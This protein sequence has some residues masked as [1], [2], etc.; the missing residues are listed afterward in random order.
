MKK[1]LLTMSLLSLI[2]LS[3][4]FKPSSNQLKL[5]GTY[6]PNAAAEAI[7]EQIKNNKMDASLFDSK[8]TADEFEGVL[9][10]T[11]TCSAYPDKKIPM[12]G[13]CPP[14]A[15]LLNP[16]DPPRI[17]ELTD[18]QRTE[19][20]KRLIRHPHEHVRATAIIYLLSDKTIPTQ[21]IADYLRLHEK[22]DFVHFNALRYML[23][24]ADNV[25]QSRYQSD[26]MKPYL[27]FLETIQNPFVRVYA[28][29]RDMTPEE[30]ANNAPNTTKGV[31]DIIREP[32]Y[33]TDKESE[34]LVLLLARCTLDDA[35]QLDTELCYAYQ[36][37]ESLPDDSERMLPEM[38]LP[39]FERLMANPSPLV[40][41]F[42]M[43]SYALTALTATH[44][45][46]VSL[47][48]VL[49]KLKKESSAKAILYTFTALELFKDNPDVKEAIESFKNHSNTLISR[50]VVKMYETQTESLSKEQ[51]EALLMALTACQPDGDLNIPAD[52]E[53]M[54]KFR[55]AGNSISPEIALPIY[56]AH[57]K[58]ENE[59]VR[60]VS[61]YAYLSAAMSLEV[62]ND[63]ETI[64]NQ[65]FEDPS[66]FVQKMVVFTSVLYDKLFP[67]P[68]FDNI[69]KK[70]L[71]HSDMR[72]R[73]IVRDAREAYMN[74][75]GQT[76]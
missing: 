20:A 24:A 16:T 4:A 1:L 35:I 17:F 45:V 50:T 62:T 47:N 5:D 60:A 52:C 70:A 51:I 58:D 8:I 10:S 63:L 26:A 69:I 42:T 34:A 39:K 15:E 12:L 28:I 25:T 41:G 53:A 56:Q 38:Q 74:T 32:G 6:T 68:A 7:F 21:V 71:S 46:P 37:M 66:L 22:S 65:G 61:Y 73:L 67:N 14:L 48:M 59:T 55:E 29:E 9:L 18:I 75:L 31:T 64:V 3:C 33:V 27:A 36:V 43:S 40:R 49:D 11:Q 54:K 2:S 13:E 57:L 23:L 19:I 72:I 30:M 76:N 44:P